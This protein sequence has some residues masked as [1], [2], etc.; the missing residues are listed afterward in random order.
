V[1]GCQNTGCQNCRQCLGV[2]GA[3]RAL[4]ENGLRLVL[5]AEGVYM[6]SHDSGLCELSVLVLHAILASTS[7]A[8]G[9][10]LLFSASYSM[11]HADN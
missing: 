11:S 9:Q 8:R 5:L 7:A 4:F 3:G 6:C 1:P 2:R 10:G